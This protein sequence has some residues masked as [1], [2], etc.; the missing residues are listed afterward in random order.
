MAD[1]ISNRAGLLIAANPAL[2]N[3]LTG[4]TRPQLTT[5]L[6]PIM[7][8]PVHT[9]T[10]SCQEICDNDFNNQVAFEDY[11]YETMIAAANSSTNPA[12]KK[13]TLGFAES[14]YIYGINAAVGYYEECS[15]ACDNE[16]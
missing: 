8:N 12:I 6:G 11:H 15:K 10:S 2:F 1:E 13:M 14:G 4:A 16:W 9:V 5:I 7:I 3:G